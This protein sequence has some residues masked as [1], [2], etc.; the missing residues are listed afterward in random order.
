MVLKCPKC[1][2]ANITPYMG[3]QFRKYQ[4]KKCGYIGVIVVD[5]DYIKKE[6]NS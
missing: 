3:G 5:E 4:C 6:K 1:K 2:S